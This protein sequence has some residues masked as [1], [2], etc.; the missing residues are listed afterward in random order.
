MNPESAPGSEG[1]SIFGGGGP[2]GGPTVTSIV[3][4]SVSLGGAAHHLN[5][6]DLNHS[7]GPGHG[8]GVL[9]GHVGHGPIGHGP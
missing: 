5:Q 7:H 3:P 4:G 6:S 2:L 8:A 9:G 1:N